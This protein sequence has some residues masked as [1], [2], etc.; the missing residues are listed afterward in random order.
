MQTK[1]F[2][3][4]LI[5]THQL[6]FAKYSMNSE[7]NSTQRVHKSSTA[8]TTLSDNRTWCSHQ[9][10]SNKKQ[11]SF[12]SNQINSYIEE[13][14]C[15]WLSMKLINVMRCL[16][17]WIHHTLSNILKLILGQLSPL[18]IKSS[19]L[20][21]LRVEIMRELWWLDQL[22]C[23]AI[24]FSTTSKWRILLLYFYSFSTIQ[25]NNH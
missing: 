19:L 7:W 18:A 13:L 2:F 25:A 24:S 3:L 8:L 22:R 12:K 4:P 1:T 21:L 17:E 11:F 16:E 20:L 23:L 15:L 6:L 5:L 9:I 14:D 10:I